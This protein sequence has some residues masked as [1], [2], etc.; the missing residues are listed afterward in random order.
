MK[1][2]MIILTFLIIASSCKKDKQ[3]VS[4]DSADSGTLTDARDG[5]TYATI[6]IGNQW[7]MAEDLN[8]KAPNSWYYN[9][10]S[11]TYAHPYGRLYLW[12]T[13]MNGQE[14]SSLNP[15]NVQGISPA[16]WHI[17]SDAEWT[18]LTTFLSANGLTA[19]DLK[20]TGTAHWKP[21][22]NG[23]NK[24]KFGAVPSGTIYNNGSVSANI[25]INVDYLSTTI[26]SATGGTWGRSLNGMPSVNRTPIGLGN[27]WTLR[28]VKDK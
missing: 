23:T 10:D 12:T 16:G 22:N 20:E 24:T 7:W 17:P 1:P 9:N 5:Q 2:S 3:T 28:C 11:S 13:I 25:N 15:S 26:D 8:Y 14:S 6:K 18:E 21:T 4:P 27:A 19:D